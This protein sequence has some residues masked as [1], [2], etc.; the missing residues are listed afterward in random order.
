MKK[1]LL[2]SIFVLIAGM[3]FSQ[4]YMVVNSQKIFQS[5]ESYTQ[6]VVEL[7][8]LASQ[9]Q[10]RIENAYE[11]LDDM[12]NTY[13]EGRAYMSDAQRQASEN[14]I[15]AAEQRITQF[16]E[17][18]FGQEGEMIKK[19]IETLKPI[20][21]K[22]F[23]VINKYAEENKFDL[24]LDIA[25]NPTILYYVPSKDKTQQIINLLK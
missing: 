13:Q 22:V 2:V 1:C 12:Y 9:Y 24:V 11:K 5:I 3:A 16:E 17:D 14:E 4:N 10:K 20:Q 18:I 8:T 23:D 19:R 6:A 25:S 7:D 21:D 15:I